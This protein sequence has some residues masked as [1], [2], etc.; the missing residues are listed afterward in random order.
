MPETKRRTARQWAEIIT[1]YRASGLSDTLFCREHG[2]T[3]RTFRKW[4]YRNP[5]TQQKPAAKTQGAFVELCPPRRMKPDRSNQSA[6][7]N[8][9]LF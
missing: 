6:G 3:L 5:V 2:L 8:I 7:L 4:K 9:S 1:Q